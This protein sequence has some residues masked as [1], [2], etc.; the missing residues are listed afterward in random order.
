M[1]L[2]PFFLRPRTLALVAACVLG[3]SSSAA[4]QTVE[5]QIQAARTALEADRHAVVT[6]A[7]QLTD[8]EAG[9]FWPLYH[10]Y[11]A[12]MDQH[13]DALAALVLEYADLYPD[14]PETRA[15]ELLKQLTGL[16]RKLV[17][18]R[19]SYLK[20]VARTLPATKALRFAQVENRLDLALR[21]KLAA[22]IPLVPMEG[23]LTGHTTGAVVLA[24]GVPGGVVVQTSR[25]TATVAA[26]DWA[27]RRVTLVSPAGIKQTVKAGPEVIN[28][29]Q[30]RVGDQL[31]LVVTEELVVA[32]GG[33]A[34]MDGVAAV[35]AL[36]PPGAK[37]GGVLAE[38]VQVTATVAAIDPVGRTATLRFED[39]TTRTFNVRSDVNLAQRRV[40]DKVTFRVTEMIAIGVQKR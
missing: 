14:V 6:E 10:R 3:L 24:E 7:L 37:P 15:K 39:G 27:T 16:E 22:G 2:T 20:K 1:N 25:L 38:T 36:A 26:I 34:D 31:N 23:K 13:G 30:I 19:A 9:A 5:E 33:Q 11:R 8:T 4:A 29:D 21:L 18:T 12:A 40:G 28:F 35:V 32:M 17:D